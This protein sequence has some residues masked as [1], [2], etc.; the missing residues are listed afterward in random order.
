MPRAGHLP[1]LGAGNRSGLPSG[2]RV[3]GDADDVF[4]RRRPGNAG[5]RRRSRPAARRTN[6]RRHMFPSGLRSHRLI[7]GR[8]GRVGLAEPSSCSVAS[9]ASSASCRG[10]VPSIP[11]RC[12]V[13]TGVTSW[14]GRSP[15]L[16]PRPSTESRPPDSAG[17]REHHVAG[18]HEQVA[19]VVVDHQVP[20]RTGD[21]G[22]AVR[23]VC[24]VEPGEVVA[25]T[26]GADDGVGLALR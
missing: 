18:L 7:L 21:Q 23:H 22:V 8:R 12:P 17:R 9:L 4:G 26:L 5:V 19:V 24:G 3:A 14:I 15:S 2:S 20:V 13:R 6:P 1:A 16:W 10:P 25:G 11:R